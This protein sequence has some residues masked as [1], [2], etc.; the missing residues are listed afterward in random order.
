V[1]TGRGQC[2]EGFGGKESHYPILEALGQLTRDASDNPIARILAARAPTWLIQLPSLLNPQQRAE[3]QRELL[4]ATRERMVREICE[5]LEA[6]TA[7]R[8]LV[9]VLEDLHWVDLS[10]LDVISA[11]ARRRETAKLMLLGTYRSVDAALSQSPL[12]GLVHDLQ[13]HGL[14]EEIA[15][16]GLHESE[17]A[18]YLA[19]G[20]SGGSL[21]SDLARLIHRH[22]GGN[23]LFMAAIARDMVNKGTLVQGETGWRLAAPVD[24]IDPGVPETLQRMLELQLDQ[25]S[26][27][28]QRIL[29]SASVAGDRFSI[30]DIASTLDLEPERI[31]ELCE[32]LARR[33]Q[34][35][36][37]TEATRS[38]GLSN[39][40][41]SAH[42]EFRHSLCREVIYRGLS[43]VG[44]S[45]LHRELGQQLV[46]RCTTV[47]REHELASELALHFERGRDYER[48]IRYLVFAAENAGVRFAHRDAIQVLRHGLEL[49]PRVA[50]SVRA[51][52]EMELLELIGDAHFALGAM[53]ES[54]EAYASA[55]ARAADAGLEAARVG[56]LTCL[57]RPLGPDRSG[58]GYCCG[59]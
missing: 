47:R 14:C 27:S 52:L 32:G 39:G 25:L 40:H 28:E 7:E 57:M 18:Q 21:P 33:L 50:P 15:L 22:S 31:E 5:A 3:L 54:A 23:A 11:L 1:R 59:E 30:W 8:P 45:R 44:R 24:E 42:Y 41:D 55:A 36:R 26:T 17:V 9:L 35:I 10:T 48:A 51:R 20:F 38:E 58:P 19:G 16:G 43:D 6:L 4:G 34:L 49:V 12:K 13:V 46:S 2:V 53:A 29:Q 37:S 56:A